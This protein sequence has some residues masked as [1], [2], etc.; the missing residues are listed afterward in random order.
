M[1][2]A[3]V[4]YDLNLPEKDRDDHDIPA[5]VALFITGFL[6]GLIYMVIGDAINILR[7]FHL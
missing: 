7:L 2:S 4:K 3:Q 5:H 6:A 1:S